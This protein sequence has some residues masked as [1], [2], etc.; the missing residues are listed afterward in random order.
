MRWIIALFALSACHPID[1]SRSA[2]VR[3]CVRQGQNV[4]ECTDNS[5]RVYPNRSRP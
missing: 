5:Y 2:F 4:T 3:D 1:E